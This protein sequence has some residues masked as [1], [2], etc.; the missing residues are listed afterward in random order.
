M[1]V[2]VVVVQGY[3]GEAFAYGA[4]LAWMHVERVALVARYG[5]LAVRHLQ[6]KPALGIAEVG[7]RGAGD[8]RELH[9]VEGK[10]I[11]GPRTAP[12]VHEGGKLCL[13][14]LH[15][16]RVRLALIPDHTAQGES[17]YGG[18]ACLV[19]V[20]GLVGVALQGIAAQLRVVGAAPAHPVLHAVVVA[21]VGEDIHQHGVVLH[22]VA[23]DEGLYGCSAH[24]IA[25][26][27][28]GH[29][30]RVGQHGTEV[31]G[32]GREL[33]GV[34]FGDGL[35]LCGYEV[36]EPVEGGQGGAVPCHGIGVYTG[37]HVVEAQVLRGR[38]GNV[39]L[40]IGGLA[41]HEGH[42][43]LSRAEPYLAHEEIGEGDG[44]VAVGDGEREGLVACLQGLE[45]E[46][47][48][49]VGGGCG[50]LFL[51]AQQCGN[52]AP[53]VAL[54][55]Q[56]EGLAAL[57]HHVGGVDGGEAQ[58]A[59]V[60]CHGGVHGAGKDVGPLGVGV[61]G[62]GK[63][64]EA[65]VERLVQVDEVHAG[66]LRHL[67]DGLLYLGVPVACAR[68]EAA[69]PVEDGRHAAYPYLYVGVGGAQGVDE[70]EVVGDELIAV[71]GPVARVGVV[72]P[73]VDDG[74]V[75]GEGERV[76]PRLLVDVGAVPTAQERG[77]RVPEV[78]H[79]VA[80]AQHLAEARGVGGVCRVA[81]PV[82]VGDAVAY[83]GYADGVG[84]CG[85]VY[86]QEGTQCCKQ[87][88]EG[89]CSFHGQML[90]VGIGNDVCVSLRC[91]LNE[92]TRL[93]TSVA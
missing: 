88:A 78:A 54:A 59:V 23:V 70:G 50:A 30:E 44:A 48:G 74:L 55:M 87:Q 84:S 67:L 80:V 4:L 93:S 15:V 8:A 43:R 89:R 22:G 6:G 12:A 51:F 68:L 90:C 64:V 16:V 20:A 39:C 17:L 31:V 92:K 40:G 2:A 63:E 14:E 7:P 76:A 32:D 61:Q 34:L 9:E 58:T 5:H 41:Q 11:I 77:S 75:G 25:D 65:V 45:G 56:D 35:P 82:P 3:A 53:C 38:L 42:V 1:A 36:V 66:Y 47:P 60:A 28:H 73:E 81:V 71:V 86:G 62:I 79:F 24:G 26:E 37:A 18:Y 91:K 72:E 46:L 33:C 49:A 27:A 13:E 29:A 85:A 83:A 69:V 19:E 21:P 10:R 52:L 57:Y